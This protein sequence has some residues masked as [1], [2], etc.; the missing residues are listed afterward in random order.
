MPRLAFGVGGS[1]QPFMHLTNAT[2]VVVAQLR[3]GHF[4][5]AQERQGQTPRSGFAG[6]VGERDQQTLGI[7]LA[8]IEP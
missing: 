5:G 2:Q 4:G 6:C 1:N 8:I 3:A 7:Q